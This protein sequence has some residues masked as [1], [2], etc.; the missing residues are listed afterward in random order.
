MN[1]VN[2]NEK[3]YG[4]KSTYFSGCQLLTSFEQIFANGQVFI[5]KGEP[6][7]GII[8]ELLNEEI[9]DEE[10]VK[11]E[12]SRTFRSK[13]MDFQSFK[14]ITIATAHGDPCAQHR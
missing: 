11:I 4:G 3:S 2:E 1:F 12:Q 14:N 13:V 6:T 8:T 7:P 10:T 5:I 9:S